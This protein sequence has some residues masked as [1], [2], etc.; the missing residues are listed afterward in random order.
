L[1]GA[2]G[3]VRRRLGQAGF[4][5]C[6]G[7]RGVG[8]ELLEGAGERRGVEGVDQGGGVAED[9]GQAG[10]VAADDGGAA[11]HGLEG[12]QAEALHE[13]RESEGGGAAVEAGQLVLGHL[14]EDPHLITQGEGVEQAQQAAGGAAG[15]AGE[16][17][18]VGGAQAGRQEG[19]GAQ[20][21][22]P[23]LVP[24]QGAEEQ[25]VAGLGEVAGRAVG[26]EVGLG[27]E[28]DD[29]GPAGGGG[30]GGLQS[31]GGVFAVGGEPPGPGHGRAGLAAEAA[32]AAPAQ[33]RRAAV[34]QQRVDVVERGHLARPAVGQGELRLPQ[35]PEHLGIAGV[36]PPKLV[37]QV[38]RARRLFEQ[39]QHPRE[40]GARADAGV[41]GETHA[42]MIGGAGITRRSCRPARSPVAPPST[43]R[44]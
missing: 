36:A 17:Q 43:A 33:Q 22:L 23:V 39:L 19:I 7:A 3:A 42:G 31:L 27:V 20:Q 38:H 13:R 10:A 11:G 9:F 4:P 25:H 1:A 26:L 32:G 40:G 24:A 41:E 2:V 29:A 14:V 5:V 16:Q 37:G 21:A 18:G 15:A 30:E 12:G 6:L 44:C 34:G 8:Q 35:A 28:R